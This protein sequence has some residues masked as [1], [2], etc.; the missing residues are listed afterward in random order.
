[1]VDGLFFSFTLA[2]RRGGHTPFAQAGAKKSDIGAEAVEQDP[3]SS[4]EGHSGSE[5]RCGDENTE[6]CGLSAHSAFHW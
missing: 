2:S 1:M 5:C 3:G 4:W 6:S